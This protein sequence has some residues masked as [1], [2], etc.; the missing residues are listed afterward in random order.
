MIGSLTDLARRPG[1]PS[2]VTLRK[3]IFMHP[4]FPI[5][6]RGTH[7]LKYRID[8]E[9]AEAFVREK[10]QPAAPDLRMAALQRFGREPGALA[11][12]RSRRLTY[13]EEFEEQI[14]IGREL[15]RRDMGI[16]DA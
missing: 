9:A 16:S 11:C 5:L 6:R 13:Q 12:L 8:L 7:G 10:M 15:L 4:D 3:M 1:M 14:R 2:Q